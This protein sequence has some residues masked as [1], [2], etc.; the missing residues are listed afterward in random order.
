MPQNPARVLGILSLLFS[1]PAFAQFKTP[2]AS[3]SWKKTGTLSTTE[4]SERLK[5]AVQLPLCNSIAPLRF[6]DDKM[7]SPN[8]PAP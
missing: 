5:T 7:P 3:A 2:S 4:L 6:K 1:L 8:Q